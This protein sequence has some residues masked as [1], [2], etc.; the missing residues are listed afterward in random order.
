[1]Y[2]EKHHQWQLTKSILQLRLVLD[3][4]PKLR[5]VVET[6]L[7]SLQIGV[8]ILIGISINIFQEQVSNLLW[9]VTS[10]KFYSYVTYI[11]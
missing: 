1:M 2:L 6:K 9:I 3:N 11:C 10:L 5:V 7:I 8:L 4:L